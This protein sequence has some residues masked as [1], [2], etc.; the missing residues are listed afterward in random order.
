MHISGGFRR[1]LFFEVQPFFKCKHFSSAGSVIMT[2][3][4]TTGRFDFFN[5]GEGCWWKNVKWR[6]IFNNILFSPTYL[7]NNCRSFSYIY[8]RESMSNMRGFVET[9]LLACL[10]CC[11]RAQIIKSYFEYYFNFRAKVKEKFSM[12]KVIVDCD[13]GLAFV[14]KIF[15]KWKIWI[16]NN[17]DEHLC[18]LTRHGPWR[19]SFNGAPSVYYRTR[20]SRWALL[21]GVTYTIEFR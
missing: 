21:N 17:D 2:G 6:K 12:K 14:I 18:K 4:F 13:P 16:Q 11:E 9:V 3:S 15:C 19:L 1:S 7:T 10:Y 20:F 5:V 8:V